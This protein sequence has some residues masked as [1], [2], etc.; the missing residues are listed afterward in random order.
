MTTAQE[1][2]KMLKVKA[3]A[4]NVKAS[5]IPSPK[6]LTDARYFEAVKRGS[7]MVRDC[8]SI[9]S[10][11]ENIGVMISRI[12]SISY[13]ATPGC[14]TLSDVLGRSETDRLKSLQDLLPHLEET[15]AFLKAVWQA[16]ICRNEVKS[17]LE[18]LSMQ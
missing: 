7:S 1:F 9:I 16:K 3:E 12:R 18:E 15:N 17:L 6:G 4:V 8:S 13:T 14:P 2:A 11:Q 5:T 10:N